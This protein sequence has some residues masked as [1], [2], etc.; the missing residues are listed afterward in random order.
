MC[1]IWYIIGLIMGI[2]ISIVV[3]EGAED[4][5]P[6]DFAVKFKFKDTKDKEDSKKMITEKDIRAIFHDRLIKL[7]DETQENLDKTLCM[8][9]KEMG[10]S[11]TV[12]RNYYNK[13]ATPRIE[14]LYAIAYYYGVSA[15]YLV[16]LS[17][18]I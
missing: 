5:K 1:F 4:D 3:S 15:D 2:I 10:V 12:L 17:D 11:N 14:I 13:K 6:E 9:A 16:G 8:Q 18:E 7:V